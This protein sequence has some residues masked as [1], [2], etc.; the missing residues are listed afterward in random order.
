MIKK[1]HGFHMAQFKNL[2][3]LPLFLPTCF[4]NI[5]SSVI[6][7]VISILIFFM[8]E[9]IYEKIQEKTGTG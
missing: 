2:Q 1:W 9:V 8:M 5:M 4:C 7:N 6:E 3:T